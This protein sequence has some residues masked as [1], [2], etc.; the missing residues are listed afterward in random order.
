MPKFVVASQRADGRL[1]AEVLNLGGY[2]LLMK[3][4]DADEV[5]WLAESAL[6]KRN[7]SDNPKLAHQ[8]EERTAWNGS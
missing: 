4:L 5:A 3:P 2:D 7:G 8:I 1:W 6:A